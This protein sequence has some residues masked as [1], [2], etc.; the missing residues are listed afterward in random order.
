MFGRIANYKALVYYFSLVCHVD[1]PETTEVSTKSASA[2]IPAAF[3]YTVDQAT[4]YIEVECV[5]LYTYKS[6]S[7]ATLTLS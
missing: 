4:T 5:D 7:S 6:Q 1:C 2:Q 3:I